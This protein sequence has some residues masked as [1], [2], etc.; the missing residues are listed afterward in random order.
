MHVYDPFPGLGVCP[1]DIACVGCAIVIEEAIDITYDHGAI[2][3]DREA[4]G[5]GVG[6]A[7]HYEMGFYQDRLMGPGQGT[8]GCQESVIPIAG[9][10]IHDGG[11]DG[12]GC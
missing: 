9:R 5:F 12:D 2:G 4:I 10:V 7:G 1:F 11:L 8:G 6:Y 3:E